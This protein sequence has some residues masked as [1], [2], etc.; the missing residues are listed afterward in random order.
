MHIVWY[1]GCGGITNFRRSA[2][3]PVDVGW[4]TYVIDLYNLSYITDSGG[5]KK[6]ARCWYRN[7]TSNSARWNRS[8]CCKSTEKAD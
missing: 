4:N 1:T 6:L 2:G 7:R 5:N 3:I 8:Y